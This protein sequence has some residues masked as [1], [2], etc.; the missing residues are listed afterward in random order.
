MQP[1]TERFLTIFTIA[2][3]TVFVRNMPCNDIIII[4]VTLCQFCCKCHRI[5]PVSRAVRAG[6]MTCSEFPLHA[7]ML[8]T[9]NIRVLSCHPRR[10]C[11]CRS[12]KAD[13]QSVFFHILHDLVQFGKIISNLI[14]LQCSPAEN[15]KSHDINVR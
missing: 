6:I 1:Y 7:I 2:F 9:Q 13:F 8:D 4:L 5:F 15:I 11:T 12:C 10:M 14:R 3:P